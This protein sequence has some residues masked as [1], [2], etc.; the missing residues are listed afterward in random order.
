MRLTFL[1]AGLLGC[2]LLCGGCAPANRT[3]TADAIAQSAGFQ[4][5]EIHAAPF[6]LRWWG[7]ISDPRQ[8]LHLYVEGDGFA[9]VTPSQPSHDPTPFNPVALRLAA[10]DRAANVIYLA[11][12]CQFIAMT[13]SPGCDTRWWTD[14]R[15]APAVIDAMNDAVSQL[16]R[17]TPG[18]PVVLTGYSG[19]GAVAALVAAKRQDIQSLRT[20]AGN[21]DSEEV[22]RLHQASAMPGSLNAKEVAPALARLPQIHFSGSDDR[23]VPASVTQGYAQASHSP[24]VRIVSVAGMT[25]G[26]DWAAL[27]PSLLRLQPSCR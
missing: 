26:G 20:V 4:R 8:P 3:E 22:N 24:C 10:A 7:R 13:R 12:P 25:H 18:Q 17:Q 21:L 1:S 2:S 23:V 11:R 19:G 5:G 15:F 6:I 27:W 9:W 14:L 16:V